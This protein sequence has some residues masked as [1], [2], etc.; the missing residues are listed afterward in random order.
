MKKIILLFIA[1][2]IMSLGC[3]NSSKNSIINDL[4]DK[5]S[6]LKSYEIKG[7]LSISSNEDTYNYD[8]SVAYKERDNYRVSIINKSNDHEQ[9]ILK[10]NDEVYV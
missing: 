5:L 4:E 3:Q 9:I 6:S 2:S 1:I 10:S 7:I 8:I